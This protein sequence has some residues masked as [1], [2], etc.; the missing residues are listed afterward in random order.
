MNNFWKNKKVLVTGG[1]GFVG[2][3]LSNRLAKMGARVFILEKNTLK[4]KKLLKN[5][6]SIFGKKREL[7]I[8]DICNKKFIENIF[9][10]NDFE[11]CFHLAAKPLVLEGNADKSPLSVFKVNIMG[12]LNI[13]E[14][15]RK[16]KK[17]GLIIASTSHVYGK[18]KLPFLEEYF[19]KPSSPYE[20]SKACADILAQTYKNYYALP[21]AIAR[22]IN[23][24]GPG[25]LNKRIIPKTIKLLFQNKPP[26]LYD[27]K[28]KR[29]YLYID[30][31]IDGY[32]TLAENLNKLP[33][34]DSNII[35]NFGTSEIYSS[36]DL[37]KKIMFLMNKSNVKPDIVTG[38]R[39]KEIATQY[40]SIKKA[41]KILGWYP[42]FSLER[43]LEKT[44]EWHNNM[45]NKYKHGK[46]F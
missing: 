6:V 44:I 14:A 19:P 35:F 8:G 36:K 33:K 37:M 17:V 30:D 38:V 3:N 40:L 23:I 43:G 21:I 20:T 1:N 7:I 16:N 18:N 25:D 24:Y 42:K 11:I 22:F 27:T 26:I 2:A 41:K 29:S 15:V 13:L 28:T 4:S 5:E 39:K 32:I 45:L 31:A 12:T 10:T 34:K 9:N 46:N